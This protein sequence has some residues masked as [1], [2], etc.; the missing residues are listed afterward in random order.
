MPTPN[1]KIVDGN[2]PF[3][4]LD[5]ITERPPSGY[6]RIILT[7]VNGRCSLF[8][9]IWFL[10]ALFLVTVVAVVT[11]VTLTGTAITIASHDAIRA[12]TAFRQG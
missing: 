7:S 11:A 5:Q 2:E 6:V 4:H 9:W 3:S 8:Q 12:S 10:S 1:G